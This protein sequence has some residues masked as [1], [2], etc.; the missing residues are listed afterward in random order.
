MQTWEQ[1]AGTG[2]SYTAP[3]PAFPTAS[4]GYPFPMP[5]IPNSQEANKALA[6]KGYITAKGIT[7]ED[8]DAVSLAKSA[9]VDVIQV[10]KDAMPKDKRDE[11]IAVLTEQVRQLTESL[12]SLSEK[13]KANGKT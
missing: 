10:L 12:K 2:N 9:G 8:V 11:Q 3:S 1:L 5:Q 4:T 13:N 7:P 6:I